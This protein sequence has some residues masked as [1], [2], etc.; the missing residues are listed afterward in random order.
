MISKERGVAPGLVVGDLSMTMRFLESQLTGHPGTDA[1]FSCKDP[2]EGQRAAY[3]RTRI[4]LLSMQGFGKRN[5]P[6]SVKGTT[7][8]LSDP[9]GYEQQ[10]E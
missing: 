6:T 3:R 9:N 5:V 4:P 8:V 10:H 2:R 7:F 1:D